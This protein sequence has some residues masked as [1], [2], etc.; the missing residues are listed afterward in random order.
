VDTV[1]L[2][3]AV[4]DEA[5]NGYAVLTPEHVSGI[6]AQLRQP[7]AWRNSLVNLFGLYDNTGSTTR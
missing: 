2:R 7:K 3:D 4:G 6:V 5:V 1:S